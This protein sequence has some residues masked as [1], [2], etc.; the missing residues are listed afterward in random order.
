M[1]DEMPAAPEAP[2]WL[3][4]P[5]TLTARPV[6]PEAPV[7]GETAPAE[8]PEVPVSPVEQTLAPQTVE[9]AS[10]T[11]PRRKTRAAATHATDNGTGL[12]SLGRCPYGGGWARPTVVGTTAGP[13]GQRLGRQ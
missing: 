12:P 10:A 2:S 8:V 5:G 1:R 13:M 11:G 4:E 7:S 6:A 3:I 9:T